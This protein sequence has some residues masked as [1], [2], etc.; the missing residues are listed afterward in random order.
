MKPYLFLDFDGVINA[1]PYDRRWIGPETDGNENDLFGFELLNPKNWA[2]DIVEPDPTTHFPLD[3]ISEATHNGRTF[4]ITYSAELVEALKELIVEDKVNFLW[5]TTWREASL[6]ELNPMLGFP[7]EKADF[8]PWYDTTASVSNPQ[9]GKYWGLTDFIIE[10]AKQKRLEKDTPLIWVDDVATTG[11]YN[12]S[13]QEKKRRTEEA[14]DPFFT[15]PTL[16]IQPDDKWGISRAE[17]ALIQ[18]MVNS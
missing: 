10:E 16:V 14:R 8:L 4:R 5:L 17:L 12:L 1:F 15:Y 7:N 9:L 13:E 6:T 3:T 11:F 18:E 2:Y